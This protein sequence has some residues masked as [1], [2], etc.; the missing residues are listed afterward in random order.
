MTIDLAGF[1]DIIP[2]EWATDD[3]PFAAPGQPWDGA[4]RKQAP[5]SLVTSGLEPEDQPTAVEWNYQQN[6]FGQHLKAMTYADLIT[7]EPPIDTGSGV[8][9]RIVSSYF[10]RYIALGDS[11]SEFSSDGG[12]NWSTYGTIGAVVVE[13]MRQF[14]DEASTTRFVVFDPNSVDVV[15]TNGNPSSGYVTKTDVTNPAFWQNGIQSNTISVLVG[16]RNTAA[17]EL[18]FLQSAAVTDLGVNDLTLAQAFTVPALTGTQTT[19]A[20]NAIADIAIRMASKPST[21]R[22]VCLVSYRDGSVDSV[23]QYISDDDGLTWTETTGVIIPGDGSAKGMSGLE[24]DAVRDLWVA[25]LETGEIFTSPTSAEIWTNVSVNGGVAFDE[26]IQIIGPFWILSNTGSTATGYQVTETTIRFGT[27]FAVATPSNGRR[28][29]YIK[30]F[31]RLAKAEHTGFV[32]F[33]KILGVPF[34]NSLGA[35]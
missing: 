5:G 19:V 20:N 2:P 6:A 3:T 21:N 31:G 30:H 26:G 18:R 9:L 16:I 13:R 29:T 7:L 28:L 27:N 11:I 4:A 24:Y 22:I 8:G 17:F 12:Y 15:S 23:Y 33:G 25:T 35:F 10:S 34:F 1:P 14:T 32:Q